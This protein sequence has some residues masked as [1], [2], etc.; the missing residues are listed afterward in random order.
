MTLIK[1]INDLKMCVNEYIGDCTDEELND[2]EFIASVV[3]Q[4]CFS[5]RD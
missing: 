4:D 1:Q 5:F 3:D 2:R